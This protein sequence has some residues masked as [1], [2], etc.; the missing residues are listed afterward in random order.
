MQ[1]TYQPFNSS[2]SQLKYSPLLLILCV[3]QKSKQIAHS[4]L[5]PKKPHHNFIQLSKQFIKNITD[6]LHKYTNYLAKLC[7][8]VC[9]LPH[10]L[11]TASLL[12]KDF[13]SC[14]KKIVCQRPYSMLI[15]VIAAIIPMP[16]VGK[17]FQMKLY[18]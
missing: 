13:L 17:Y 11:P 15:K 1:T 14:F 18:L 6:K 4:P 9:F 2:V 5:S 12:F 3:G 7:V 10:L 8:P 16:K